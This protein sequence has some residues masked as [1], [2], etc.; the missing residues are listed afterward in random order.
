MCVGG[1]G[2][3]LTNRKYPPVVRSSQATI[4]RKGPLNVR[5]LGGR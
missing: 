1:G 2:G 4:S 3:R 5:I